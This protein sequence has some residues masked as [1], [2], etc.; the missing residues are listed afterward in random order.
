[1][2]SLSPNTIA[3][4]TIA[5]NLA[6]AADAIVALDATISEELRALIRLANAEL[7]RVR[8][9]SRKAASAAKRAAAAAVAA[10]SAEPKQPARRGRKP[11]V[12][13]E[14][15]VEVPAFAAAA[16]EVP[17]APELIEVPAAIVA[18]I[19]VPAAAEVIEVPGVIAA[20][21]PKAR[22]RRRKEANGV[23]TH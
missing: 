7:G 15:T 17:A 6:N 19:E 5:H 16:I 20:T 9:A 1:M 12:K 21:A 22:G 4:N 23:T 13:V 3:I 2:A 10:A 11:K 18:A 8:K 14:A